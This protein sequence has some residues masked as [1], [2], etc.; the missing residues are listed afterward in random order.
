MPERKVVADHA[1]MS[2][3]CAQSHG[4]SRSNVQPGDATEICKAICKARI[5]VQSASLTR[6]RANDSAELSF[7]S[8]PE[9]D[10]TVWSAAAPVPYFQPPEH[11]PTLRN[12]P[13]HLNYRSIRI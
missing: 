4:H 13:F 10:L 1:A 8:V 9:T 12:T 6:D 3:K 11:L 5:G 2:E 7:D